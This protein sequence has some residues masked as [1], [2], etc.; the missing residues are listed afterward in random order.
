MDI[1]PETVI[2]LNVIERDAYK[3]DSRARDPYLKNIA[4]ADSFFEYRMPE[5]IT[6]EMDRLKKLLAEQER[7]KE[8]SAPYV[9]KQVKELENKVDYYANFVKPGSPLLADFTAFK[10]RADDLSAWCDNDIKSGNFEARKGKK[11]EEEF[12][13]REFPK[14]LSSNPTWE[15]A[16]RTTVTNAAKEKGDVKILKT[17]TTTNM[18]EIRK[19]DI[20][21]PTYRNQY[22]VVGYSQGGK[23][24]SWVVQVGQSYAGGGTWNSGYYYSASDY[25]LEL[26]CAKIH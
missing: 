19:N 8:G 3:K 14:A 11:K 13:K 2:F 9:P 16:A 7:I 15:A 10:K 6:K 22:V 4:G 21:I 20:D 12:N 23:C 1:L 17:V 25:N 18:W 26:P 24:Y 5:L